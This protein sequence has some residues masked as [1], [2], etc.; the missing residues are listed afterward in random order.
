MPPDISEAA[1]ATGWTFLASLFMC[2]T[3]TF[4]SV[5]GLNLIIKDSFDPIWCAVSP[6]LDDLTHE[7]A[8]LTAATTSTRPPR[9]RPKIALAASR[10]LETAPL[11]ALSNVA[12]LVPTYLANDHAGRDRSANQRSGWIAIEHTSCTQLTVHAAA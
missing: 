9:T 8:R 6:S 3:I 1:M 11:A 4:V 5:C 2:A 10:A 7:V 12:T